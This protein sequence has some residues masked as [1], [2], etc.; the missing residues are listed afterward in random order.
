MIQNL[1]S[2]LLQFNG[3]QNRY[4]V[5]GLIALFWVTFVSDIDLIYLVKSKQEINAQERQ[6]RHYE[7]SIVALYDQLEDLSSNPQRLE[8]FA[9]EHYFMKRDNEDLFRI[10]PRTGA[11]N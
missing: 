6:V 7:D 1:K 5:T 10:L 8:R 9:R 3:E 11:V 4:L 2:F